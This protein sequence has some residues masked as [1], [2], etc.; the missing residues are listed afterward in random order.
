MT[1]PLIVR[2]LAVLG[3]AVSVPVL[4]WSQPTV[5]GV[6]NAASFDTAVPLGCLISIFGTNLAGTTASADSFPL[7]TQIGDVSV[8]V[9]DLELPAP[10]YFVSPTQINAQLPFE[11]LGTTLAIVVSTSAGRSKPFLIR[12]AAGG[13]GLFTRDSSGTGL[14]LA[15]TPGFQPL[16]TITSGQPIILYA[17]GLGPTD[18]PVQSGYPGASQEPLNRVVTLP[19]VYAGEYPLP[20]PITFAGL[21]PGLAGVYQINVT[22]RW[23]ASDRL[24]LRAAGKTSNMVRIPL[25]PGNNVTNASGTMEVVYPTSQVPIT[26]S[27]YLIVVRFTARMDISPDAGPFAVA[28]V[29]EG[30]PSSVIAIDPEKGSYEGYASEPTRAS[31]VFDFSSSPEIRY[32]LLT[33]QMG[34]NG[35]MAIPFPAN[36]LPLSRVSAQEVQAMNTLPLPNVNIPASASGLLHVQGQ[37]SRGSTFV[38]DGSTNSDL[39]V[40]AGYI[41]VHTLCSPGSQTTTVRLLIDGKQVA[42]V[43]VNYST[44]FAPFPGGPQ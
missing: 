21:A 15:F 2:C 5:T 18:P 14:A 31:R 8:L 6:V 41:P 11:A 24:Y 33:C 36:I 10:L 25:G 39:S 27:P 7:P 19:E 26:I 16:D 28:A 29:T 44:G 30:I 32:D 13:P 34:P 22:P 42:A 4:G 9:G 12:P 3:L 35:P 43:D 38:I 20:A 23:L 1:L 40:F 37:V 17:T